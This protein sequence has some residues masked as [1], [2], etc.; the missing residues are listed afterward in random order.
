MNF[1]LLIN[2]FFL[3]SGLIF[4]PIAIITAEKVKFELLNSD[5]TIIQKVP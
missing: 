3:R 2:E 4:C 5:E 1:I